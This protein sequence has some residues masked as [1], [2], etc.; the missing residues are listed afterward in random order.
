MLKY[1]MMLGVVIGLG[2]CNSGPEEKTGTP[3]AM[4]EANKA[5]WAKQAGK[6]YS[7]TFREWDIDG[8]TTFACEAD[9]GVIGTCTKTYKCCGEDPEVST[10]DSYKTPGELLN[11]LEKDLARIKYDSSRVD[12]TSF[13]VQRSWVYEGDTLSE[14]LSASFEPVYGYPRQIVYLGTV[15]PYAQSIT[16]FQLK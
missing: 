4:V 9:K 2:A 5:L 6:S 12:D 8:T 11:D 14:G 16:Q 15:L 3:E 1:A 7:I 10:V 13:F